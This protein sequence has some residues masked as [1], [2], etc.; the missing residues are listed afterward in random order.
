VNENLMVYLRNL[1]RS[2]ASRRFPKAGDRYAVNPEVAEDLVTDE[3]IA[4]QQI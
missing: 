4:Q 1:S 3:G 2:S